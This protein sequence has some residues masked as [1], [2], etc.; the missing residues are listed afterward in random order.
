MNVA[1]ID[2]DVHRTATTEMEATRVRVMQATSWT[3][4]K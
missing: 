1:H 3:Q 4:T 2:T